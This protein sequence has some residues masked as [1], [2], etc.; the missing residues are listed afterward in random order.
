MK[1]RTKHYS[2]YKVGDLILYEEGCFNEDVGYIESICYSGYIESI[3]YSLPNIIKVRW[4]KDSKYTEET[5]KSLQS[6]NN[7]SFVIPI[8]KQ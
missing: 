1:I 8:S 4:F 3:C 6:Y 7:N 5:I 2:D